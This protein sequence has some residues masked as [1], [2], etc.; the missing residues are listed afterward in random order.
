MLPTLYSGQHVIAYRRFRRLRDGDIV[1]VRDPRL[2]SRWIVKRCHLVSDG[3][4]ELRG[5]NAALS[6]DSRTFGTLAARDVRWLVSRLTI[7]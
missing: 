5:D 7:H 1:V 4:V 3:R 2:A 6:T